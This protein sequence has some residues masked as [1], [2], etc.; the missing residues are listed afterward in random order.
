MPIMATPQP[1]TVATTKEPA[2][3]TT[4]QEG[5]ATSTELPTDTK[6]VKTPATTKAAAFSRRKSEQ[7]VVSGSDCSSRIRSLTVVVGAMEGGREKR[8]AVGLESLEVRAT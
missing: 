3:D 1:V 4:A 8:N 6:K 2:K 7:L 5:K